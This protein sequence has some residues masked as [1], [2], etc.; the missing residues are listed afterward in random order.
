M[1]LNKL[2]EVKATLNNVWVPLVFI[3]KDG[4]KREM[5]ATTNLALI[6]EQFHPKAKQTTEQPNDDSTF[7]VEIKVDPNPTVTVFEQD[8]GWRSFK[9]LS[10][11]EFAGETINND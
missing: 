6:P 8:K 7:D 1:N 10:L 11:V 3:K 4:T 5:I 9:W 2:L